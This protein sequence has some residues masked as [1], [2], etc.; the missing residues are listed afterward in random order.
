MTKPDMQAVFLE[1]NIELL[2]N[3]MKRTCVLERQVE[4]LTA[5]L[6][7]LETLARK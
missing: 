3:Y 1:T 7:V 5:R 6:E 4:N 2:R